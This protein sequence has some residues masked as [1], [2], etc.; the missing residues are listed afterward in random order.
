MR[1]HGTTM[2]RF[3]VIVACVLCLPGCKNVVFSNAVVT[4]ASPVDATPY[5]GSWTALEIEGRPATELLQ[6]EVLEESGELRARLSQGG[7]EADRRMTFTQL[8]TQVV[9]SFE[10]GS[11]RW[12]QFIGTLTE[13]DT[14]LVVL[15]PD[16][17]AFRSAVASG[18]LSG[19]IRTIDDKS[20][21]VL[22]EDTGEALATAILAD[23]DLFSAP[24]FL[25]AKS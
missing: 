8:G 13:G 7:V 18:S 16:H 15:G 10:I 19:Q 25:L 21:T 11:G 20:E 23:P 3:A 24:A 5:L 4:T 14:Q 9:L 1:T 12:A 6:I 22:V 2:A 17:E